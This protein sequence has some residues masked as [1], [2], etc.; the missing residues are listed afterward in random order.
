M[1]TVRWLL[2]LAGLFGAIAASAEPSAGLWQFRDRGSWIQIN[3]DGSAFRC[4]LDSQ[5]QPFASRGTAYGSY[6]QWDDTTGREDINFRGNELIVESFGQVR[7]YGPPMH[8][9]SDK[10][11]APREGT[12]TGLWWRD[13]AYLELTT[14]G[15]VFECRFEERNVHSRIGRFKPPDAIEW[16]ESH[17]VEVASLEAG[18]L[19][20][21]TPVTTRAFK[22]SGFPM[23]QSCQALEEHAFQPKSP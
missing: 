23:P 20:L 13:R 17:E 11:R 5:G 21:K 10:C 12:I 15:N 22:R 2:V 14:D 18:F 9:I 16:L 1:T 8:R 7:T 19:A 4:Y 3:T 6:I